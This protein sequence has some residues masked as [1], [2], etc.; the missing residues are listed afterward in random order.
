MTEHE[1]EITLSLLGIAKVCFFVVGSAIIAML[2]LLPINDRPVSGTQFVVWGVLE[3][4]FF[5]VVF[6]LI[7]FKVVF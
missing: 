4:V 1:M 5:A 7:S 3:V 2:C 6:G